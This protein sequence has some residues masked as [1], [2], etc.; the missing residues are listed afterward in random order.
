MAALAQLVSHCVSQQAGMKAQTTLQQPPLSQP[1]LA[2]ATKQLP[3]PGS[4]QAEHSGFTT[5]GVSLLFEPAETGSKKPSFQP[6]CGLH[7]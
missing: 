5:F 6:P 2:W 7:R 4:P 3:L 1:G